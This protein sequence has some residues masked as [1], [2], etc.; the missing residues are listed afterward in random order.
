MLIYDLSDDINHIKVHWEFA[1]IIERK[2]K[3]KKFFPQT[4]FEHGYLTQYSKQSFEIL[5]IRF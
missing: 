3:T 4:V 2:N 1:E 5:L